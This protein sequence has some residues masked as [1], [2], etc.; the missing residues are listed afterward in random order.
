MTRRA[1]GALVLVLVVGAVW[2]N[3]GVGLARWK[4]ERG[5]ASAIAA[6]FQFLYRRAPDEEMYFA[7]ASATLGEPYDPKAFEIRGPT[8][9]PVADVP[10]DGR[11][12][13]PYAEVPFEYPPPNVPF[14]VAPRLF[15][16]TFE[17]YARVF[18]AVMAGLLAAAAA[19]AARLGA[20]RAGTRDETASRLFVFA[21]LLLAHGA[22]AIQRLDAL[23]AL[24]LVLVVRAGVRRDDGALG[25]WSGLVGAT[26]V[27]P[28]VVGVAVL[29]ATRPDRARVARFAAG[30]AL[31][32][33]LGFL[34]ML[35]LS[36]SSVAT[37]L[38][39][40]GARGLN[41]ESTLGVLYGAATR[42][43][44]V[45]DFGS[46]NFHGGVA[47]AL[48]K[49]TTVLLVVLVAVVL[50]AAHRASSNAVA[51]AAVAATLAVWLGGKVFS[52]QYLTW[53]L[54]LV[55]AVPGAGWRRLALAFGGVLVLT[56]LYYR[57][58]FDHVYLQKPLGV[59]TMLARLALLGVLFHRVLRALDPAPPPREEAAAQ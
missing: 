25:F 59:A 5:T 56:Q 44:A 35:A 23:V 49:L 3:Q 37:F 48:A 9:L 28:F 38:R 47:D 45:L 39:Y 6:P 50:R 17:G 10:A 2:L 57:G 27:V 12:H 34:P 41:V 11:F 18:G 22:I 4:A 14:V 13:V 31:G 20:V 36:P 24:L 40:H 53:M 16:G 19:L 55:L 51:L 15:A 42:E 26:K 21:G 8:P 46:F 43:R 7:T 54:P 32:L 52:P 58:W 1:W 30:S 33:G 29:A